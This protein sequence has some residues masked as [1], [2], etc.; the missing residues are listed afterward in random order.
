MISKL[1]N[2]NFKITKIDGNK[3]QSKNFMIRIINFK[4]NFK[5]QKLN[6]IKKNQKKK[7][8]I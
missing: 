5:K 6:T 7:Q 4:L 2:K 1:M 3:S 8:K